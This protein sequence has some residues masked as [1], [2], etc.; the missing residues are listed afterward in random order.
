[1]NNT[2]VAD[3]ISPRGLSHAPRN[4]YGWL[5]R[6]ID[7]LVATVPS[8]IAP[9]VRALLEEAARA[10]SRALVRGAAPSSTCCAR[11]RTAGEAWAA[12]GM[13]F[14]RMI[15]VFGELT[16]RLADL[17][18]AEQGPGVS[19]IREVMNVGH[20]LMREFLAGANRLRERVRTEQKA[21]SSLVSDLI[22]GREAHWDV[23][24]HP[25]EAYLIAV[26]KCQ[27][28]VPVPH[29][30][31][32]VRECGGDGTLIGAAAEFVA[33]IPDREPQRTRRIAGELEKRLD[34]QA[35][36]GVACRERVAIP[37]GRREA[38]EI[39]ALVVAA[40]RRPGVYRLDDCLVEYAV[41][42]ND[43]VVNSLV[44]IVAPL[45]SHS[46]LWETLEMLIQVGFNR[47]DAARNMFVHRST[48][49]YRL[50]KIE[51]ITGYDPMSNRGAQVLRTAMITHALACSRTGP[52]GLA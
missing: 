43:A 4:D 42:S 29:I 23:E 46:V 20:T 24:P 13:P 11:V 16:T 37:D 15:T 10:Y 31:E 5:Q 8:V 47:V 49:D 21:H 35:W 36:V 7:Q 44:S 22:A 30:A 14:D 3:E 18:I 52:Y 27:E 48:V 50:R 51:E 26:V 38:A 1:M 32:I 45:I 9:P 25:A 19:H 39:L 33:L 12:V 2:I 40:R 6:Q 41:A 17:L 28:N 34:G